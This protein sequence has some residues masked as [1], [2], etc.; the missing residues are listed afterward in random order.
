MRFLRCVVHIPE[1]L[2]VNAAHRD[3]PVLPTYPPFSY[4]RNHPDAPLPPDAPTR[5]LR[6]TYPP[7]PGTIGMVRH[8]EECP[9]V[10]ITWIRM[11]P[12]SDLLRRHR[13]WPT[14][15]SSCRGVSRCTLHA[16]PIRAAST[17]SSGASLDLRPERGRG[18]PLRGPHFPLHLSLLCA[19]RASARGILSNAQGRPHGR[20]RRQAR[21]SVCTPAFAVRSARS[22]LNHPAPLHA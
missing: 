1:G 15:E 10:T 4:T 18:L 17:W 8:A 21:R 6:Q 2:A 19:V 13:C 16:G 9:N 12:Q 7:L 5:G 3:D 22:L 20:Y 11:D 14:G